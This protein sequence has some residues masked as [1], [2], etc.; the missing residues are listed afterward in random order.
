MNRTIPINNIYFMLVYAW[1]VLTEKDIVPVEIPKNYNAIEF[2]AKVLISGTE[3]LLKRGLDRDYS[4]NNDELRGVKGK[5]DFSSSLNK[6]SFFNAKCY[7]SF[8]EFTYDILHNQIINSTLRNILRLDQIRADLRSE[9]HRVIRPFADIKQIKLSNEIFNK[10]K[11][12]RNNHYYK[13][14]ISICKLINNNLMIN[15][16]T[17]KA[18]FKNF[19]EDEK[20]MA[21]LF[22]NFIRNF[23]KKEL[24]KKFINSK[25]SVSRKKIDWK[26]DSEITDEAKG[27]LPSMWTDISINIDNY[28]FIIDTKYYKS[29]LKEHR[30]GQLKLS[31]TNLYQ[32]FTYL[33]NSN[34]LENNIKGILLYPT[35]ND[36][37]NLEYSILGSSIGIATVDLGQEDFN[38]IHKSLLSIIDL[39]K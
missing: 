25:V 10:V 16:K 19:E 2:F 4:Q 13:L 21:S 31:S 33:K 8:D 9:I 27:L 6:Q 12:N 24:P 23:Y 26:I 36:N 15:E 3:Y 38:K 39:P 1:D 17:G 32:L 28:N 18:T 11:L 5:I 20:Q 34:D 14:P 30:F 22:E 37:F 7:C 35:I 29:T